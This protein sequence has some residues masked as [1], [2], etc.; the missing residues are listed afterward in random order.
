MFVP[1]NIKFYHDRKSTFHDKNLIIASEI[2]N[3]FS[4]FS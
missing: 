4:F 2:V 3:I 1:F